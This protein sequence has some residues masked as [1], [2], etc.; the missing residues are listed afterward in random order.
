MIE[1]SDHIPAWDSDA[2]AASLPYLA[3][4]GSLL[5]SKLA[6]RIERL[7]ERFAVFLTTCP[8]PWWTAD[9]A[10]TAEMEIITETYLPFAEIA[11]AITRLLDLALCQQ[12]GGIATP[13]SMARSW[14]DLLRRLPP[15]F[16]D[17]NPARLL[18]RLAVD[19]QQRHRFIFALYLPPHFGNAFNRYPRQAT[20]LK[21]WLTTPEFVNRPIRCLD[22][23]C[24]SGE[25]TYDL[26]RLLL[27]AG[28]PPAAFMIHGT[29]HEPVELF[30]ATHAFFPHDEMR[31]GRFRRHNADLHQRGAVDRIR[32]RSE[33]LLQ[34]ADWGGARYDVI[35]CNGILGGPFINTRKDLERTIEGLTRRLAPRGIF[36]AANRFH[37][38]WQK[39]VPTALLQEIATRA[40]LTVITAGEG[41]AG[42]RSE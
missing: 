40:G 18:N 32:F 3:T 9:L 25:G 13:L 29:T 7:G 19:D 21:E 24:G 41:L 31:Q 8:T 5:D 28:Y 34:P 10:V 12:S 6:R 37:Q 11:S 42:F 17:P 23:A 36:L 1:P 20:F 39:V 15:P 27:K 30:A 14:L 2:I 22:A 16:Q 4:R 33:D 26:A 38:G 35:V